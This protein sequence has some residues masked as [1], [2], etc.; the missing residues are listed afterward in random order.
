M[1]SSPSFSDDAQKAE[2]LLPLPRFRLNKTNFRLVKPGTALLRSSSS[3]ANMPVGKRTIRT[4]TLLIFFEF[5]QAKGAATER[6][7]ILPLPEE[8]M[9]SYPQGWLSFA[10]LVPP[11]WHVLRLRRV[12]RL[13]DAISFDSLTGFFE[14][15]RTRAR[16]ARHGAR[17]FAQPSTMQSTVATLTCSCCN[18]VSSI[19]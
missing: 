16:S 18:R 6:R 4:M 10:S 19:F 11:S 15:G 14:Q 1:C 2:G 5:R 17:P 13:R 8:Y 12:Q 7:R 3:F 9:E